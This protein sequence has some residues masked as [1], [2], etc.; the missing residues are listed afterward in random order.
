MDEVTKILDEFVESAYM[1]TQPRRE[2]LRA[3]VLKA[4]NHVEEEQDDE[5]LQR[6]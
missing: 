2:Q 3:Q 1:A 5:Q 6:V 4:L